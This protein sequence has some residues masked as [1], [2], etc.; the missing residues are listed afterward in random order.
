MSVDDRVD[1]GAERF[2]LLAE[3]HYPPLRGTWDE[4]DRLWAIKDAPDGRRISVIPLMYTAAVA[5]G[6]R[7][8]LT[9]YDDRWCYHSVSAAWEAAMRWDGTGEP[10]GWHRHPDTGRRRPGGDADRE[11]VN[12]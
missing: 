7:N 9:W 12:R 11:Y 5:I 3:E 2:R 1:T 4:V 6:Q 10:D 8:S